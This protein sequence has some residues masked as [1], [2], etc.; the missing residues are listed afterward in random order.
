M[1]LAAIPAFFRAS[2]TWVIFTALACMAACAVRAVVMTPRVMVA[3]SGS[4]RVS[5]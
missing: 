1:S 2:T 4:T 3:M 5:P